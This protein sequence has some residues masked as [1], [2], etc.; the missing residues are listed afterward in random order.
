[1]TTGIR[2]RHSKTCRAND[3]GRC[4]CNAGWEAAV[5]DK[6]TGQKVRK[7]FE[8]ESDAKSWRADQLVGLRRGK[9]VTPTRITLREASAEFLR[10]AKEGQIR[11]R[12]GRRY[13][14]ATLRGYKRTLDKY[15]LPDL[16]ALRLTEIRRRDLQDLVDRLMAE[17]F[18]ASSLHNALN[19]I[20]AIFRRALQ[21][22][23]VGENPTRGLE[24]PSPDGR[25][26]RIADREEAGKLLRALPDSERALWATAF[27]AGLRRGELRAL[28]WSDVDLGRSEIRVERSWDQKEGAIDPK[29]AAGS[30]TVPIL[31]VLRDYLD[32]H[33]LRTGRDGADLVFGRTATEAFCAATPRNRALRAWASMKPIG[34]HEARHTFASLLIDAGT[35]P[36][37]IQEFMGHASITITFDVYGHLMP[38]SRDEVR[39][40]M[41]AYLTRCASG[42]PVNSIPGRVTAVIEESTEA[43]IPDS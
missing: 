7:T 27:Y 4:N 42:A 37:A 2:K 26:D 5:F 34:F 21:R 17:G 43:E 6:R 8:R 23:W 20:Q 15:L 1:M 38:G 32:E 28:R 25:R 16:G 33:K 24:L 30:R 36:K 19:P 18:A 29:S 35:N 12:N 11:S 39:E 31:A 41:D 13:S 10:L 14:P 9:S 22:E 40:R 3:G